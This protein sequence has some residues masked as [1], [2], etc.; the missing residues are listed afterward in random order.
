MPDHRSKQITKD[1]AASLGD[2]A[3]N[4]QTDLEAFYDWM[5]T[6]GKNPARRKP[7][8]PSQSENY[9]ARVDQVFRF[10]VERIKPSDETELT[11]DQADLIVKWLDRDEIRTQSGDAY[12]ETSKRK[13]TNALQKYFAWRHDERDGEKWRPRIKFTDGEHEHAD[14][15]NFEERWLILQEAREYGSLPS[16]YETSEDERDKIDSLVAQRLGKPK[17]A[18]T[19]KDWERADTSGKIGSLIAVS[20]ETGIIPI[21]VGRARTDWYDATRNILKITKED[22]AKDRPTTELPLSEKTGELLGEWIQERRHYEKYDG[23][24]RLWLNREGNPYSSKNL[25]YL[26]RRLCEEAGIEHENRKIVWYSLR[27][28]LG[29]SIEETRDLSQANDQLRHGSFETTKQTYGESTIESR[30]HTLET[31]N[32]TARRTV[33]EPD[34]NPYADDSPGPTGPVNSEEP[35]RATRNDTPHGAPPT[36]GNHVDAVIDDTPESRADLAAKILSGDL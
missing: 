14:R 25:C 11:H 31:I 27:H 15:L 23:T 26:L 32:E 4:V 29:Q 17:S 35:T 1:L 34:F 21:E 9:H 20:L 30:R 10:V 18:V 13:F 12:T 3:S 8:S 16:Y 7:L 5:L 2:D 24:N 6:K 28:N 36:H 19:R 22:A 33:E